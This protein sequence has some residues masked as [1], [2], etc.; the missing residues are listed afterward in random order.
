[1]SGADLEGYYSRCATFKLL[2]SNYG[3]DKNADE[4][5]RKKAGIENHFKLMALM[6]KELQK[7]LKLKERMKSCMKF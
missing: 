3:I 1:M 2:R 4:A 5:E 6:Y 7:D